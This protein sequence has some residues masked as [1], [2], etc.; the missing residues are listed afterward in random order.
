MANELLRLDDAS[1]DLLFREARTFSAWQDRPVAPA[2][3]EEIYDEMKWAPTSMNASPLRIVF[4][5]TP[6][7]KEKLRPTLMEGNVKQTMAAPV[8]AILAHD[9]NFYERMDHL[10]PHYQVRAMFEQDPQFT[11]QFAFRN[12]TLQAAYFLLAAR[13]LGLDCGPMS[14]FN[15]AAVDEAFFPG[16]SWRSNFLCNLGYGDRSKLYPRGPRLA[17]QE[18]VRFA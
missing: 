14:G 11:E 1:L 4:V 12:G 10:W 3:L 2:L 8:T 18:V 13:G 5:T 15:N 7:G 17:F 9:L 16:T 6:E